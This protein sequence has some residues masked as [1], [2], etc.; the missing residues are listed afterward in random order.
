MCSISFFTSARAMAQTSPMVGVVDVT[1]AS[2]SC[3]RVFASVAALAATPR[4]TPNAS[5]RTALVVGVPDRTIAFAAEAHAGPALIDRARFAREVRGVAA[6]LPDGSFVINLCEDRYRFLV[7]FCA[8]ALR[9]QTTLLPPSRAPRASASLA[10]ASGGGGK[11]EATGSASPATTIPVTNLEPRGTST[12]A[13]RT[14][15]AISSGT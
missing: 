14:G 5:T 2:F 8:A 7:V 1:P 9:G 11:P 15:G 12:R 3:S 13:P 4:R 6:A 10:E